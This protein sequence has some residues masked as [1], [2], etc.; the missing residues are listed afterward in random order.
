MLDG[1]IFAEAKEMEG[2]ATTTR[3]E[4]LGFHER[5]PVHKKMLPSNRISKPRN[6]FF[7]QL[8]SFCF[9]YKI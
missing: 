7:D 5:N 9:R 4:G 6:R 3:T 8:Q 1:E 2:F